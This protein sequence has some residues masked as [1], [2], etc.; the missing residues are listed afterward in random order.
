M[1]HYT[2]FFDEDRIISTTKF[3]VVLLIENEIWLKVDI[4][5]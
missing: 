3:F 4:E 2:V 5:F 1:L